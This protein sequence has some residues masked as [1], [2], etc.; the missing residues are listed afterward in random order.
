MYIGESQT[1][2]TLQEHV[3]VSFSTLRKSQDSDRFSQRKI[4]GPDVEFS[5]VFRHLERE[6]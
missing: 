3:Y 4:Y 5:I 6:I 1:L 2:E